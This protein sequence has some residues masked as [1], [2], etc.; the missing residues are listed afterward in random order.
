MDRKKTQ[1]I[2]AASEEALRAVAEKFG[3]TVSYKSGNFSPNT[4]ALRFEFTDEGADN[5]EAES[6]RHNAAY[7]GMTPEDLGAKFRLGRN[8]YTI[9]GFNARARKMPVQATRTDGRRFK[10]P[11]ETVARALKMGRAA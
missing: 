6:F 9:T 2:A 3:V 7:Y 10:F 11:A 1:E 4:A 5:R 8:E